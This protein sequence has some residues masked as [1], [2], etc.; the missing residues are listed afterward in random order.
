MVDDDSCS[1]DDSVDDL[2]LSWLANEWS[3]AE[4]S[5]A[6]IGNRIRTIPMA[7][8]TK[9][10]PLPYQPAP[11]SQRGRPSARTGRWAAPNT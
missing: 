4:L 8:I 1:S 10:T 11:T 7:A 3:N 5:N 6:C 2:P 9:T